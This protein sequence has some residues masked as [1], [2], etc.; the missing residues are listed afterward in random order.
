MKDFEIQSFSI[1]LFSKT[2]CQFLI[3]YDDSLIPVK[4]KPG[5]GSDLVILF[6]PA[7]SGERLYQPWFQP[8]LPVNA[9]QLSIADPT[10]LGSKTL[11]A[12]WF[13]GSYNEN[14]P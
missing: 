5:V 4:Y 2:E 7:L 13:L 3:R 11:S 8:F 1:S 6:H 14:L 10:L 12:G 9:P